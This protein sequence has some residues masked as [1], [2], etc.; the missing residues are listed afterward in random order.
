MP[1][2]RSSAA[3]FFSCFSRSWRAQTYKQEGTLNVSCFR[4]ARTGLK[5]T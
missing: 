5:D 3:A 1:I 4:K 2:L